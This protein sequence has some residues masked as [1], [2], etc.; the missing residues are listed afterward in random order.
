MG[1]H[2]H[3]LA[4]AG[5]CIFAS[6]IA[7]AALP[8]PVYV[9][10]AKEGQGFLMTKLGRCFVV[11]A[12][13]VIGTDIRGDVI[14]AGTTPL[15]G[16]YSLLAQD[17]DADVAVL[18]V[19]RGPLVSDCGSDYVKGASED[20][21]RSQSRAVIPYLDRNGSLLRQAYEGL[22]DYVDSRELQL[23]FQEKRGQVVAQGMSGGLVSVADLPA[24]LLLGVTGDHGNV[25]RYEALMDIVFR[26]L[27][28]PPPRSA[29]PAASGLNLA[30]DTSGGS[31]SNWSTQPLQ[32]QFVTSSLL[33]PPGPETWK[34]SLEK[35]PVSVDIRLAGGTTRSITTI[36]LQR[37]AAPVEQLIRDYE[38][39]TSVD[40]TTWF[41][42]QRGEFAPGGDRSVVSFPPRL[43]RFVR[44]RVF[45]SFDETEKIGA[46]G[47]ILVR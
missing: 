17:T 8:P 14:S 34:V 28:T 33:R 32:A 36:E 45:D 7:C 27:K 18:E 16:E 19:E 15:R 26:L 38:V 37:G 25:L 23:A 3:S 2:A 6:A 39:S 10:G 42:A 1:L 35:G 11:T 41:L 9:Q 12:A 40:G 4:L 24:G 29:P 30:A 47:R 13:H 20:V 21:L 46:L 22:V 31:L 43:A 44:V 5:T